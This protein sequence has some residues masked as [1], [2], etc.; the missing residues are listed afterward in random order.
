MQKDQAMDFIF[1]FCVALDVSARDW[2]NKQKNGGQVLLGKAMDEFCPLGPVVVTKDEVHD[3]HNLGIRCRVNGIIKQ[4]SNTNQL[5]HRSEAIIA[6]ISRF[7]TLKQGDV[8]LT[9]SP[10]GV[11]FTRNPP[12]FLKRGDVVESEI[13]NIGQICTRIV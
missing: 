4:N 6:H 8:V 12:E 1:G 13:Q 7:I 3:V 5:V 10:P 9:G 2:Q 11:G